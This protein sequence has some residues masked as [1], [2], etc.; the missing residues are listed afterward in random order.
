MNGGHKFSIINF[1]LVTATE[2]LEDDELEEGEEFGNRGLAPI[3][4]ARLAVR[5]GFPAPPRGRLSW[6]LLSLPGP[7][8]P[9]LLGVEDGL[10]GLSL[11]FWKTRNLFSIRFGVFF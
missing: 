8:V 1:Y 3:L 4:L 6:L 2:E 5:L 10:V 9:D 11:G 7:G